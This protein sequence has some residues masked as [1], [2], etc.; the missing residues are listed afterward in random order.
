MFLHSI[1]VNQFID[2]PEY[3]MFGNYD[4]E[5]TYQVGNTNVDI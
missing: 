2:S 1:E 3:D 4:S 5:D